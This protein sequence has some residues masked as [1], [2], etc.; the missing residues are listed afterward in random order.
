VPERGSR[1]AYWV[2]TWEFLTSMLMLLCAY[3]IPFSLALPTVATVGLRCFNVVVDLCF[4][5]DV[6]VSL[7]LAYRNPAHADSAWERD[8]G[9]IAQR[10]CGFPLSQGGEAG[11]FW[12]DVASV[13]PGWAQCLVGGRYENTLKSIRFFRLLRMLRLKRLS[14][15]VEEGQATTGVPFFI[16]DIMKFVFITTFVSHAAACV[17][18]MAERK[19][20]DGADFAAGASWLNALRSAKGD[21]CE[22]DAESDPLCVYFLALYWAMMT[23]TTVGYGDITPQNLLEYN[24]CTAFMLIA[25]FVWAYIVGSVVSLLSQLDPDNAQFKQTMDE[26][27]G[28]IENRNLSP[29]L[30]R[31]LREY[32]VVAKS[33]GQIHHQQQLLETHISSGLQREVVLETPVTQTVLKKVYWARH[34]EQDALLEIIRSLQ[35]FVYGKDE[36]I[37]MK[38][39]MILVHEGLLAA[40]GRILGRNEV[41]GENSILL[42]SDH[43]ANE[44]MPRTL[45]YVTVLVLRKESLREACEQYPSA[46]RKLRAAQIRTA[47]WRGF[48]HAAAKEKAARTSS[49]GSGSS[50][51]APGG[52]K[53]AAVVRSFVAAVSRGENLDSAA[54]TPLDLKDVESRLQDG[55][56]DLAAQLVETRSLLNNQIEV[57]SGLARELRAKTHDRRGFGFLTPR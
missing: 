50:G 37:P 48:I 29:A 24:I 32:M 10:Y 14:R 4:T 15:K 47:L 51:G 36:T 16:S 30:R 56:R 43:L 19:T 23:L 40:K 33:V 9:K 20:E 27:N 22:P 28:L 6:G 54:V 34:L 18:V 46:D 7:L 5:L 35:S 53:A 39:K 8:P 11:W 3:V 45:S 55:H 41:Y 26:L 1:A 31:K 44:S 13:L 38:D 42:T 49:R 25:G 2:T 12:L 52:S 57:M 17:W 21:C